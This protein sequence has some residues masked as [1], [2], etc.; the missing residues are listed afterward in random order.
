MLGNIALLSDRSIPRVVSG[1]A[2]IRLQL[3]S[4]LAAAEAQWREFEQT[5]D[6]TIF[7]T[8]DWLMEWY[9][10]IGVNKNLTPV[11][12]F[13]SVNGLPCFLFP[14]AIECTAVRRLV[15]LGVDLADYNVP[16][17]A[18]NFRTHVPPGQ[19]VQVWKQI[20]SLIRNEFQYDVIEL[21]KMP[22]TIGSQSN[23]FCDLPVLV[24]EYS[25]HAATLAD[26]WDRFYTAKISTSSRQTDR[27]KLRR[28]AD[29]GD[30]QFVEVQEPLD[31]K[32]TFSAL[33]EQKRASYA[34]MGVADMFEPPGHSEFYKAIT[35]HPRF[36]SIVH[37]T[38]VD[39]G[40][41]PAATGLGLRFKSRYY[42]ILHSYQER[43]SK[44]SPGVHHIHHLLK[45]AISHQMR[46]FDF[47]IGDE[48]YKNHWSDIEMPLL[49]Y[50][51]GR[52]VRG[53]VV[54]GFRVLRH[55]AVLCYKRLMKY[56]RIA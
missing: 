15:W 29:H 25:A 8:F 27:R 45:Y 24:A 44:Y 36:R 20:V 17:L 47:T 46:I 35:E 38:R 50:Y 3:F 10:C 43:Y 23:P 52:T 55:H 32:Y 6:C 13:G 56:R 21:D 34:R 48:P 7:Q 31:I 49:R 11:I 42:L 26:D 2:A 41:D 14:L 40:D 22:A 30:V 53:R 9:R 18:T 54:V 16:L 1:V 39:V 51:Q 37:L 28:L 12:V 33:V 5:A 4:D 19:F